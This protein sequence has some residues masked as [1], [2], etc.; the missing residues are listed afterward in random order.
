[1]LPAG[2][3]PDV[4]RLKAGDPDRLEDGSAF[5]RAVTAGAEPS[6]GIEPDPPAYETGARPYELQGRS[7]QRKES[8]LHVLG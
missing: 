3:E 6:S 2:F 8:N 4:L 5:A 7:L 1:M